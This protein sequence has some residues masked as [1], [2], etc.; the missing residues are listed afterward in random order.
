MLFFSDGV[1]IPQKPLVLFSCS[2]RMKTIQTT[3]FTMMLFLFLMQ[4]VLLQQDN[5]N[6]FFLHL[7]SLIELFAFHNSN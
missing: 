5:A 3:K 1:T 7:E 2:K 4:I 6:R